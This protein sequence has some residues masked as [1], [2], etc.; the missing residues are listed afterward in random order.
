MDPQQTHPA[1]WA[2]PNRSTTPAWEWV[3]SLGTV[4]LLYAIFVPTVAIVAGSPARAA[5]I[6]TYTMLAS[7]AGAAVLVAAL[8][9]RAREYHSM[10]VGRQALYIVQWVVYCTTMLAA[11]AVVSVKYAF[12]LP[13]LRRRGQTECAVGLFV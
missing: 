7:T 9:L 12:A 6:S 8:A 10:S 2:R 11:A 5:R 3:A 4:V 13:L 1:T